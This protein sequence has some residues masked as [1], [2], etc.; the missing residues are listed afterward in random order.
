M[1]WSYCDQNG[2]GDHIW[3][4]SD[5]RRF[6]SDYPDWHYRCDIDTILPEL[7]E[8]AIWKPQS[9]SDWMPTEMCAHWTS[10]T[11]SGFL[12]RIIPVQPFDETP[13]RKSLDSLIKPQTIGLVISL[14]HDDYALVFGGL[15]NCVG[16]EEQ[17]FTDRGWVYLHLCPAQ[18]L[19]V[20]AENT[21]PENFLVSVRA[22]GSRVGVV[23]FATLMREMGRADLIR[24]RR[25]FVLHHLQG[26]SPE[27][28][29]D[30]A[31]AF[32][33]NKTI[34]WVHDFF[35][36][37]PNPAMLRN[38]TAFCEGPEPNSR[39]CTTCIYG[40]AK[41]KLHLARLEYL[42]DALRPDLLAPSEIALTFWRARSPL[43]YSTASVFPHCTL[44]MEPNLLVRKSE[45]HLRIGFAAGAWYH[46]GWD[47]FE[48]LASRFHN[49]PRYSFFHLGATSAG[50]SS[51]LKF[52]RVVVTPSERLS[53]TDAIRAHEIDVIVNWSRCYE[54]FC[55]A[56]YEAV[57]AGAFV[58]AR[59]GAGNI[60][61]A[62]SQKGVEQG[63]GLSSDEELFRLFAGRDLFE[64][65]KRRRYGKLQIES[66]T[67]RYLARKAALNFRVR[68][69]RNWFSS[70]C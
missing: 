16:D 29:V 48:E 52:I 26:F 11:P 27:L 25:V 53:M 22:N 65:T 33:P 12:S 34:A 30:L 2:T 19:P 55:F 23:D 24:L 6:Q 47:V 35:T 68:A 41:R 7:T 63:I 57:A 60:V 61:P 59:R 54:T 20:L 17:A 40:A 49:D 13:L 15:Q 37:C 21:A 58:L 51:K 5:I 36:L 50:F 44:L 8:G 9:A 3:W 70:A 64:L 39:D 10:K 45:T 28:V 56:A 32:A 4:I 14:S 38:D 1:N 67:M 18:P 62:V 66:G 69:V 31:Q 42:F 43:R 46:K